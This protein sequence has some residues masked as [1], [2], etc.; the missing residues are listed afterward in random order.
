MEGAPPSTIGSTASSDVAPD[1]QWQDV[2]ASVHNVKTAL[3][4]ERNREMAARICNHELEDVSLDSVKRALDDAAK[5]RCCRLWELEKAA[6]TAIQRLQ[7]Q[8]ASESE[9]TSH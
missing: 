9:Q 6:Q 8:L 7:D 4:E 3:V 5:Q 2:A 1:V